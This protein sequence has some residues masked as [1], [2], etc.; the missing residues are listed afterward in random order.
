MVDPRVKKQAAFVVVV[1]R[2]GRIEHISRF[3]L[4]VYLCLIDSRFQA[5]AFQGF[6]MT[7]RDFKPK[8]SEIQTAWMKFSVSPD[9]IKRRDL[10]ANSHLQQRL[11][12]EI[13]RLNVMEMY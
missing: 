9:Q 3:L 5:F 6:E 1:G 13:P 7:F 2:R 8:T 10:E 11:N 12:L 4:L